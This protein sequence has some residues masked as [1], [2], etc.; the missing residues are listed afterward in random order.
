VPKGSHVRT[1]FEPPNAALTP[2]P[3][4]LSPSRRAPRHPQPRASSRP[5]PVTGEES[6]PPHR[7]S[8]RQTRRPPYAYA[9][10]EGMASDDAYLE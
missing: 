7:P 3:Q 5:A 10:S 1:L 2:A 9:R 4:P 8:E 6:E